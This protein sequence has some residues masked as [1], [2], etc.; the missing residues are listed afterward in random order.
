[1]ERCC[2]IRQNAPGATA[3]E[4]S[5]PGLA[6]KA[7]LNR[8]NITV[9]SSYDEGKTFRDPVR[10]NQ[11]FAAYSVMQRLSDGTIGMLVETSKDGN[12]GY[13]EITF[14]RFDMAESEGAARD[15]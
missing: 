14:Y 4:F 15:R 3:I 1:M 2:A 8:N 12:E 11:G 9:W 10:F 7:G 5:S 13:G 6:V